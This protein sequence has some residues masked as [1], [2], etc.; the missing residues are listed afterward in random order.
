MNTLSTGERAGPARAAHPLAL[1]V[2]SQRVIAVATITG[3][4]P[5]FARP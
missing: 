5:A 3:D 4:S 2:I 1:S